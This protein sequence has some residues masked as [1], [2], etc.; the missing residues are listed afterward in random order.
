M[1]RIIV[2]LVVLASLVMACA[3]CSALAKGVCDGC[4]QTETLR[5]FNNHGSIQ[6]YCDDCYRFAKLLY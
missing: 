1:K 5:T 2:L 4:G 3:G 6:H